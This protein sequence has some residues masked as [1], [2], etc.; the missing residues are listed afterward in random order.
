M[1]PVVIGIYGI[2]GCGKSYLLNQ[3]KPRLGTDCFAHYDGSDVIA[4]VTP[5][6]LEAFEKLSGAEKSA[7]RELAIKTVAE[8]CSKSGRIGIVTGHFIFHDG[9]NCITPVYTT[10]DMN[11]F[12]HIFY[13]KV[14]AELVAQR[15]LGDKNRYR[16]NLSIN[17]L[18]C[19]QRTEI[20]MLR[21]ECPRHSILFSTIDVSPSA[22]PT[23]L[24]N[25]V[26]SLICY[27]QRHAD[28]NHNLASAKQE[29]KK[30]LKFTSYESLNTLLVFD[31]DKTLAPYDTGSLFWK[32]IATA[33]RKVC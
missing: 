10:Q 22:L 15:R 6:G 17:S 16:S 29:M 2:S 5:G 11:T 30:W 21:L 27:F 32:E 7:A 26:S 20:G 12:T 3:L 13:L 8:E 28:P 14:P 23:A 24:V 25:K 18:E 33:T 19:W 9:D 31:G 1:K 4:R